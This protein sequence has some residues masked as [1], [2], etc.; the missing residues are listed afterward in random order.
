MCTVLLFF[1]LNTLFPPSQSYFTAENTLEEDILTYDILAN[2]EGIL[3][4]E[5]EP[6][7]MLLHLKSKGVLSEDEFDRIGRKSDRREIA[8]ILIENTKQQ[9]I[10]ISDFYQLLKQIHC[11]KALSYIRSTVNGGHPSYPSQYKNIHNA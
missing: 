2:H 7:S 11:D 8:Q 6:R 9:S 5:M 3:I 4:E 1:Y 10:N